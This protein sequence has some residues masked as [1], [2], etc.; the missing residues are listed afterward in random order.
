MKLLI[1]LVITAALAGCATEPESPAPTINFLTRERV[2]H[3]IHKGSTTK[4]DIYREF[5][6]PTNM[7]VSSATVP[8]VPYETLMYMKTYATFVSV[9]MV[10]LD[11][12]GI[13]TNY[14]FSGTG[15]LNM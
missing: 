4:G 11:R 15:A 6:A 14:I 13:V 1:T 9:L 12:R 7:T 5:G 8:G 3:F 2:E 10:H